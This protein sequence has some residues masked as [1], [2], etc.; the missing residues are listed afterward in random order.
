MYIQHPYKYDGV[1]YAKIDGKYIEISR[2]V[3]K[4]MLSDY[5]NE[6]NR[7]KRWKNHDEDMGEEVDEKCDKKTKKETENP[8]DFLDD[9]ELMELQELMEELD[10][11]RKENAGDLPDQD[12]V[13]ETKDEKCPLEKTEEKPRKKK[14]F[15]PSEVM[16]CVLVGKEQK[17]SLEY[18]RDEKVTVEFQAM[19]SVQKQELAQ[20]LNRL[21]P[22]EQFIIRQTF[23]E[24]MSQK[25]IASILGIDRSTVS[26][27]IKFALLKMRKMMK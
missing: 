8:K 12:T 27:R 3:A 24:E 6:R 10:E 20:C 23:F 25:D 11:T 17:Y 26:R 1:F 5:R 21:S 13:T 9:N 4:V 16:E 15:R 14:P 19:R 7:K 2:D 22:E 18:Y